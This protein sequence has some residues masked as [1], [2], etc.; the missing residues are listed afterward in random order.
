M[1][2]DDLGTH[3]YRGRGHIVD[4]D[5]TSRE[6]AKRWTEILAELRDHCPVAWSPLTR[7]SGS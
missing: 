7:D 3:A 5:H 1:T 2:L 4:F 6:Y